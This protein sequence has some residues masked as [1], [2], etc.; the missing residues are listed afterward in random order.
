MRDHHFEFFPHDEMAVVIDI[1]H[2]KSKINRLEVRQVKVT[3]EARRSGICA[4]SLLPLYVTSMQYTEY[5]L[6]E[7]LQRKEVYATAI[8]NC[9]VHRNPHV[10]HEQLVNALLTTTLWRSTRVERYFPADYGLQIAPYKV[11]G[12][13]IGGE[14]VEK[15]VTNTAG[16][17]FLSQKW[18]AHRPNAGEMKKL[19][20]MKS[21]AIETA[22]TKASV[23]F[24][25]EVAEMD[26]LHRETPGQRVARKMSEEEQQKRT[27]L[28]KKGY[29]AEAKAVKEIERKFEFSLNRLLINRSRPTPDGK[30]IQFLLRE[31]LSYIR[32]CYDGML[33]STMVVPTVHRWKVP[34]F[35]E[36]FNKSA[37]RDEWTS[38]RFEVDGIDGV[39][40]Y[41]ALFPKG[42]AIAED[43][44]GEGRD[45]GEAEVELWSEPPDGNP[46][47]AVRYVLWLEG[48]DGAERFKEE[49]EAKLGLYG[50]YV[51]Y[52]AGLDEQSQLLEV[53][54]LGTFFVCC[55]IQAANL[56]KLRFAAVEFADENREEL[57][58][59]PQW[60]QFV[61][62]NPEIAAVLEERVGLEYQS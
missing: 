18:A 55:K 19:E 14:V 33:C 2:E 4:A 47:V 13:E 24:R 44:D 31:D 53:A 8:A 56:P 9:E 6:L 48:A 36:R 42:N 15:M 39:R 35:V 59:L 62:E 41:L 40:F 54:A 10:S 1:R 16:S 27:A 11:Y 37:F 7:C 49:Q 23:P 25:A 60:P 5:G 61:A 20:E 30:N 12:T 28:L 58:Q 43:D 22:K 57:L 45:R 52:M 46:P 29:N 21:K 3:S 50:A 51:G 38:G 32:K 34:N 26:A 17:V